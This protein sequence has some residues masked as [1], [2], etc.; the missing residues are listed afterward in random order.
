MTQCH[1]VWRRGVPILPH[2]WWKTDCSAC[3]AMHCPVSVVITMWRWLS[4]S[5]SIKLL[6]LLL[7]EIGW[8]FLLSLNF[9]TSNVIY[10]LIHFVYCELQQV[11]VTMRNQWSLISH[12]W[13]NRCRSF[14]QQLYCSCYWILLFFTALLSNI[15][16]KH[17]NKT[18]AHTNTN[19][20][21][22][23]VCSNDLL[24]GSQFPLQSTVL[25]FRNTLRM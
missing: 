3:S 22:Q 11:N 13:H 10:F 2:V 18:P 24:Q 5:R 1:K 16:G 4:D 15:W 20:Q 21:S 19:S 12:V 14:R 7:K 25:T 6:Q 23:L 9:L 17:K 8:K